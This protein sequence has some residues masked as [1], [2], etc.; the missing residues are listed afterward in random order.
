MIESLF[1]VPIY[2]TSIKPSAEEEQDFATLLN[3]MFEQMPVN[4]WAM[5]S[6]KSTGSHNLNLHWFKEMDWLTSAT[7]YHVEKFWQQLNYRH[8]A[9]IGVIASWAN[10]HL[11]GDWTGD[12][13]HCGGAEQSHIS[14][15]YY[16][17]K[18][19][20]SGNIEFVDPLEYVKR[21]V[22][23]HHYSELD[24]YQQIPA[25]QFDLI[26]FPSWLKHRTQ[27]NTT[28]EERVA[29]SMNFVGQWQL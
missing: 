25:E 20:N 27:K 2:K 29:V 4:E 14:A 17:K 22:P 13:T 19:V 15:V 10:Q 12:H 23:I 24:S 9:S 5:E 3:N 18:P 7:K 11:Q 28:T 8:G 1:S 6:G 26:L 21:M 16:F